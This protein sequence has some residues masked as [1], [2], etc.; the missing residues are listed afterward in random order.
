MALSCM[1]FAEYEIAIRYKKISP[2][3]TLHQLKQVQASIL[4][5]KSTNKL[6]GLPSK[7]KEYAYKILGLYNIKHFMTPYQ[8]I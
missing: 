7:I 3:E 5:G 1:H 4:M 2:T 6:Y 8:I